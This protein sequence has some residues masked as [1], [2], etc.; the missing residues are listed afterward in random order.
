M[1]PLGRE[2]GRVALG[3]KVRRLAGAGESS[4]LGVIRVRVRPGSEGQGP[5]GE[6]KGRTMDLW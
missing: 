3:T 2:W 6:A 1:T 5:D 4:L